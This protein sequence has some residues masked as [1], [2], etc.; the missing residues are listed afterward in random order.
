MV[1]PD[2]A[3][4][5]VTI[6]IKNDEKYKIFI[7]NSSLVCLIFS[8]TLY[9]L[10]EYLAFFMGRTFTNIPLLAFKNGFASS[11]GLVPE[12]NLQY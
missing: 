6:Y 2:G 12:I 4:F 3:C 9:S 8:I 7:Y 10:S 11:N 1:K 5:V